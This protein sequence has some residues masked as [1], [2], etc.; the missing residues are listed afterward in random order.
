MSPKQ[1]LSN[2]SEVQ[3]PLQIACHHNP[4]E[5]SNNSNN[6]ADH[7]MSDENDWPEKSVI[8]DNFFDK[9]LNDI[10]ESIKDM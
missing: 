6:E 4:K 8:K 1:T 9:L 10:E 2:N 7:V 3:N 5:I